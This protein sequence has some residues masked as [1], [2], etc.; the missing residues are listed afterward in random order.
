M[1]TEQCILFA[2]SRHCPFPNFPI[3]KM[4]NKFE[5]TAKMWI[6]VSRVY[7]SVDRNLSTT[8]DS[9]STAVLGSSAS[10]FG[11]NGGLY[12]GEVAYV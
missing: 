6:F 8:L 11:G 9:P 1:A 10:Q 7:F 2:W 4:G 12:S 5:V 3:A